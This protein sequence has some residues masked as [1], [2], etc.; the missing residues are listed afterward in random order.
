MNTK[1]IDCFIMVAE[2]KSFSQAA[3]FLYLNQSVVSY[4]INM[5]EKE[6]NFQLFIRD[7]H[8]VILSKAGEK[9]FHDI[10]KIRELYNQ[11]VT[12]SH[13]IDKSEKNSLKISW[14]V[15][16]IASILGALLS[17]CRERLPNLQ[18]EL[19]SQCRSDYLED[20]VNSRKDIVFTYEENLIPDQRVQFD[21]LWT[22]TN[23]FV[24][25]IANPL[26]AKKHLDVNDMDGQVIFIPSFSP[27]TRTAREVYKSILD[28][29]PNA[30]IRMLSDFEITAMPHVVA[31]NGVAL[32]PVPRDSPELGIVSRPFGHCIPMIIGIAYRT[33]DHSY[34]TSTAVSI[35]KNFSKFN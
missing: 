35:S 11:V 5:L 6:L 21:P 34:K 7:T 8:N 9:F 27:E 18:I 32:Y 15:F 29:F 19:T 24:M 20:L 3:K 13:E 2:L 28:C 33:D 1:Q 12:E 23:Y 26:A 25:N 16:E 17:T 31:N 10:K 14:Q 22:V 30:D 4:Q